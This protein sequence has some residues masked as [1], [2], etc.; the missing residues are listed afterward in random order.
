MKYLNSFFHFIIF[1]NIWIALC[2][3]CS[4]HITRLF[5]GI[6]YKINALDFFIFFS[7]FSEYNL[8]EYFWKNHDSLQQGIRKFISGKVASELRYAIICGFAGT[9]VS[10]VFLDE[11]IIPLASICSAF[12]LMYSLPLIK[13]NNTLVRLREFPFIKMLVVAFVW[14]VVTVL[15][16][17][18]EMPRQIPVVETAIIFCRRFLFI[19]ALIIPF[20]INGLKSGKAAGEILKMK[21]TG[22]AVLVV[23][24]VLAFM[25]EKY[26]A[27]NIAN[28]Q[29]I[30]VPLI[31]SAGISAILIA[32]YSSNSSRWYNKFLV[33]GMMI[34]QL[35]LL[36]L[37][38]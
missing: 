7:A 12:T 23:F 3:V 10:L 22:I 4:M 2:A 6:P 21:I 24:C 16:P 29:N 36:L 32:Y 18:I 34:L 15:F 38:N 11:K 20:E 1:N 8:H 30:F 14:T 28:R 37:F 19:Y 31:L 25:Q 17:V 9:M 35:I 27:F 26:L 5:L 13:W 33:D